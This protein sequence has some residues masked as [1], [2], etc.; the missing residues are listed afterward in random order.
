MEVRGT[1]PPPSVVFASAFLFLTVGGVDFSQLFVKT[2]LDK[3]GGLALHLMNCEEV[4]EV[5]AVHIHHK[6]KRKVA[7]KLRIIRHVKVPNGSKLKISKSLTSDTKI[8]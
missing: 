8:F 2:L 4:L 5:S 7:L 3:F 1:F 6:V